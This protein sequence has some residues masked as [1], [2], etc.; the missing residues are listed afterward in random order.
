V[1][2]RCAKE[3]VD[4]V[5]KSASFSDKAVWGVYPAESVTVPTWT[6]EF[7]DLKDRFLADIPVRQFWRDYSAETSDNSETRNA[8]ADGRVTFPERRIRN[9]HILRVLIPE[10]NVLSTGVHASF[11]KSA[12]V[13]PMCAMMPTGNNSSIY[14][15]ASPPAKKLTLASLDRS[16][17]NKMPGYERVPPVCARLDGQVRSAGD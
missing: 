15:G 14:S 1:P 5:D 10:L 12:Q 3:D 17:T 11:G 8:D 4:A 6:V 9:A 13:V 16:Y 2:L 7:V